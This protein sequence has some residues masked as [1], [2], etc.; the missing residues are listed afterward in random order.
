[1]FIY[2]KSIH[3]YSPSYF[4]EELHG[5]SDASGVD[6]DLLLRLH[7]LPELVKVSIH[8]TMYVYI[9]LSSLPLG[10]LFNA[11]SMGKGYT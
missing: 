4:F 2:A 7:M 1:M 8:Y 3:S 9:D 11:W 5:L 10:W 6:Y